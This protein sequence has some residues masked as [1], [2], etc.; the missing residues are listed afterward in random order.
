[1]WG[2]QL[3]TFLSKN[4][5]TQAAFQGVFPA[6][7][8]PKSVTYPLA[9]VINTSQF[10]RGERHWVA[11]YIDAFQK[12]YYFDSFG[13]FPLDHRVKHFLDQFTIV[14]RYSALVIQSV[15]SNKCGYFC[16]YFLYY[17][18]KGWTLDQIVQP[19]ERLAVF[20]N[21]HIVQTWYQNMIKPTQLE[22][23]WL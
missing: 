2:W 18:S 13:L 7:K 5:Y 1:M 17:K 3:E 8:L 23:I 6:E 22:Q 4:P 11:V 9:I 19:F 14:W 12:G 16:L 15:I 20:K 10:G 21:D